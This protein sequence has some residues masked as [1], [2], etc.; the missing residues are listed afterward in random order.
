MTLQ[1]TLA[2]FTRTLHRRAMRKHLRFA[3]VNATNDNL[4]R[5]PS[6]AERKGAGFDPRPAP[7][8]PAGDA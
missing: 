4:R 3:V 1:D 2:A 6:P 8:N 5:R 7:T